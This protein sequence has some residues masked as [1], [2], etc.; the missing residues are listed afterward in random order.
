MCIYCKTSRYRKIYIEHYGSI[1][2]DL[3]GRIYDIHHIDGHRTNNNPNNL[4]ALSRQDHYNLHR[5]KD[6]FGACQL[7]AVRLNMSPEKVS[8]LASLAAKK[9]FKEGRHNF[10]KQ[11]NPFARRPDGS[12]VSS[13]RVKLG[14][15]K[16][17]SHPNVNKTIYNFVH[18]TGVTETFTRCELRKKYSING[19][20]IGQMILGKRKSAGGWKLV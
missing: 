3:E 20:N 4:I 2:K 12:S 1:P 11:T 6:D 17:L 15:N 19:S 18:K 16:G 9:L 8:E 14:F 13:D 5:S 7:L 10:Q